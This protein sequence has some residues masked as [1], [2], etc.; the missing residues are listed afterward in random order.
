MQCASF[1]PAPTAYSHISSVLVSLSSWSDILPHKICV[2]SFQLVLV[3][4]ISVLICC[5]INTTDL[6]NVMVRVRD[7]VPASR[8]PSLANVR[9]DVLERL[10]KIVVEHPPCKLPPLLHL[11]DCK[12][13]YSR[14]GSAS[15]IHVW[16][17]RQLEIHLSW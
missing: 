4:L 14:F 17:Y 6:R 3:C 2:P 7:T 13:A 11:E 15:H 8:N 9:R 10:S 5:I 16:L 1:L 12:H